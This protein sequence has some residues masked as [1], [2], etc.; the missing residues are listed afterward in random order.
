MRLSHLILLSLAF[1][2]ASCF[3][4]RAEDKEEPPPDAAPEPG[5]EKLFNGKDLTGW[6]GDTKLWIVENGLL[7]GRSPGIPKNNFLAT[8]TTYDNFIMKFK[9]KI[10]VNT[11]GDANSGCQFRSKRIP[12]SH[13]L[14][15]YQADIGQGYWGCIYDESRRNKVLVKPEAELIEKAA[16]KEGWNEYTITCDGDHITLELN[17]VKTADWTETEPADKVDRSGVFALQIHAGGPMEVQTKDI[18]IKKLEKK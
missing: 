1:G 13:E 16:K 7:I 17:G 3:V 10:A 8:T 12:N 14:Y 18:R 15:G 5:F 11:K 6:E 9:F 4:L 2:L